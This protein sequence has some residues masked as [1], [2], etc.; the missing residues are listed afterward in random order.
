MN[1]NLKKQLK[2]KIKKKHFYISK[3]FFEK[4]CFLIINI[5]YINKKVLSEKLQED[6]I[7]YSNKKKIEYEDFLFIDNLFFSEDNHLNSLIKNKKYSIKK[8][9]IKS[10]RARVEVNNTNSF[11]DYNFL[12]WIS[13][14]FFYKTLFIDQL[15][16]VKV[17]NNINILFMSRSYRGWRHIFNLPV[18]GQRTWSNGKTSSKSKN[19]FLNSTYN[20]FKDGLL[21]AH[22]SEIKSSFLIEKFNSLW[23]FQWKS[24]WSVALKRRS[25]AE[26]KNKSLKFEANALASL[27]PNFIKAKKQKLIPIGFEPG[28]S[29]FYLQEVKQYNKK[30]IDSN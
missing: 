15:T 4:N 17:I 14:N 25:S 29:K 27:N 28:Y 24:E 1:L 21:N 26:K 23:L 13:F 2:I 7:N 11:V 9:F 20:F 6:Y 8:N 10:V 18:N 19:I 16:E 30:K 22:P 3:I 5:N 12:N